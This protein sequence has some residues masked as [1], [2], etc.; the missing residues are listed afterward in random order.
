ME[1]ALDFVGTDLCY[2]PL[3][4]DS[5]AGEKKVSLILNVYLQATLILKDETKSKRVVQY[6]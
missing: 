6:C 5:K 2:F 1:S 4:I 3:V